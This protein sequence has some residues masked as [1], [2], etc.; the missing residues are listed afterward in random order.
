MATITVASGLAGDADDGGYTKNQILTS[1]TLDGTTTAAITDGDRLQ[2]RSPGELVQGIIADGDTP[3]GSSSIPIQRLDLRANVP[4][5]AIVEDRDASDDIDVV[6]GGSSLTP[7]EIAFVDSPYTPASDTSVWLKVDTSGGN[8][9]VNYPVHNNE[10]DILRISNVNG[11][12]YVSAPGA[13]VVTPQS[14]GELAFDATGN[15]FWST[16]QGAN[17]GNTAYSVVQLDQYGKLPVADAQNLTNLPI[18]PLLE[19]TPTTVPSATANVYG[20]PQTIPDG[21][22]WLS[23]LQIDFDTL[24]VSETITYRVTVTLDDAS[25]Q[26]GTATYPGSFGSGSRFYSTDLAS[27]TSFSPQTLVRNGHT[28]ASIELE[29]K[30]DINNSPATAMMTV[31][32]MS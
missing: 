22:T 1:I 24:D 32:G 12:N 27:S 19:G 30:S 11:G 23:S 4:G 18:K 20:P 29:I 7:V 14:G 31:L 21:L 17:S 6:G 5:T 8:V 26:Y 13:M 15:A 9:S 16:G 28:I 2:L 10:G 25:T 3:A